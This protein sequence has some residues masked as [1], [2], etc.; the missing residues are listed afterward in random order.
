[1]YNSIK[2]EFIKYIKANDA[3]KNK[4]Y[5]G[6]LKA[7]PNIENLVQRIK[8]VIDYYDVVEL[9]NKFIDNNTKYIY[10]EVFEMTKFDATDT[11]TLHLDY[12]SKPIDIILTI[13]Q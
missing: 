11:I 4:I 7:N 3:D 12:Y 10:K 13:N 9:K 6:I 8:A 1:M 2:S 5:F